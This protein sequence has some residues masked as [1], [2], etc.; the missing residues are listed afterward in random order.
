[1]AIAAAPQFSLGWPILKSSGSMS[2]L[3]RC[4][5]SLADLCRIY[6]ASLVIGVVIDACKRA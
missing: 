5:N 4:Q 2:G 6:D 3:E 1:M